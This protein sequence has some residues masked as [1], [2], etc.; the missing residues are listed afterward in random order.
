[1]PDISRGEFGARVAAPRVLE[2]L[3]KYDIVSTWFIPGHTADTFP[4]ICKKISEQGHEIGCHGYAHEPDPPPEEEEQIFQ[5]AMAA[6]RRVSG[7]NPIGYRWTG[8]HFADYTI[9]RLLEKGFLYDSSL[10]ASEY[11]PYRIR[12]GDKWSLKEPYKFGTETKLV[13]IPI[14]WYLDDWPAFTFSWEPFRYAYTSVETMHQYFKR[15]FDYMS[16]HEKDGVCTYCMHPEVIGRGYLITMF[17]DLIRH[18][19]RTRAVRF[20]QAQE[21]VHEYS[22]KHPFG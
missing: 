21:V 2:L 17:E 19:K 22:R 15:Q 7:K 12:K 18:M 1:M 16:K 9:D 3:K 10:M 11:H 4:E 20:C 5:R 8:T 14:Q 13:E 6:I